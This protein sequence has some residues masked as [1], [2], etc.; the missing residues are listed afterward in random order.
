MLHLPHQYSQSFRRKEG[1]NFGLSK[2]LSN[3][4]LP[5]KQPLKTPLKPLPPLKQEA[6]KDT[7]A[8][9]SFCT[10]AMNQGESQKHLVSIFSLAEFCSRAHSIQWSESTEYFEDVFSFYVLNRD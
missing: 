2:H 3:P 7:C 8:V 4:L 6:K 10:S 5:L 1:I 9:C